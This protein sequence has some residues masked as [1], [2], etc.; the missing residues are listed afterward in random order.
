MRK[1]EER[2]RTINAVVNP[3]D[4]APFSKI[5]DKKTFNETWESKPD[6]ILANIAHAAYHEESYLKELFEKFEATIKFYK[7]EPDTLGLVR[8]REAF[9]GIWKDKAI[10]AF[11]GTEGNQKLRLAIGDNIRHFFSKNLNIELPDEVK[12]LFPTDLYDDFNFKEITYRGLKGKSQVHG[13]FYK[14]TMDLWPKIAEDLEGLEPPA[15]SQLFVT[16]HSLGAA[17]AVISGTKQ[18]FNKIV[19]FGEPSVGNDLDNTIEASCPHIRYVNGDDP[20]T[21][22]VPELLYQPHG[23]CINIKDIDGRNALFDHSIINYSEILFQ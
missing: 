12:L 9:M 19:T 16:G 17:M 23:T 14:A 8:G 10:L 22:I 13:G 5:P 7:S 11:R 6:A 21:K 1:I 4:Y 15:S 2:G 18:S 20:V 3:R